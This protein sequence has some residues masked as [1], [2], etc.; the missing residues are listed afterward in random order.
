[1]Y[2]ISTPDLLPPTPL[3]YHYPQGISLNTMSFFIPCFFNNSQNTISAAHVHMAV[4][5]WDIGSLP[6]ATY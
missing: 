4:T 1:M 6:E 3:P 2:L 5:P